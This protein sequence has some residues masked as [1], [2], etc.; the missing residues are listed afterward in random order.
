MS[1]RPLYF[2]LRKISVFGSKISESEL[3]MSWDS[4]F[5]IS[6]RDGTGKVEKKLS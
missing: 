2:R 1:E 6:V 5:S 3:R 4:L